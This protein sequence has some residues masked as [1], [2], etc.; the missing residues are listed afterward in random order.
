[1]AQRYD[2]DQLTDATNA[3]SCSR[4]HWKVG[5]NR[6]EFEARLHSSLSF[7]AGLE[8]PEMQDEQGDCWAKPYYNP[9]AR[10]RRMIPTSLKQDKKA[11]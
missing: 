8:T 7:H 3:R 4:V 2:P 5:P 11:H 10:R 6:M 1:M 9:A